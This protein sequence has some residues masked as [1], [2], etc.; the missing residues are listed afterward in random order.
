MTKNG[1]LYRT[2]NHSSFNQ[3]LPNYSTVRPRVAFY[4]F[5]DFK[6]TLAANSLLDPDCI[7]INLLNPNIQMVNIYNG[8]HPNIVDSVPVL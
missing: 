2:I 4:I 5:K 8:S 6:A 3:I 7:I 1:D